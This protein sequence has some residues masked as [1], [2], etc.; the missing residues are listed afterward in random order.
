MFSNISY[1][2]SFLYEIKQYNWGTGAL[3]MVRKYRPQL[4]S[5]IQMWDEVFSLNLVF[6]CIRPSWISV[7]GLDRAK[8]RGGANISNIMCTKK[9]GKTASCST[10][11]HVVRHCTSLIAGTMTNHTVQK[12]AVQDVLQ[13]EPGTFNSALH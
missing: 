5:F 11:V 7:C 1:V 10:T 12:T 3:N 13:N 4:T 9:R 6:K 2:V 8:R